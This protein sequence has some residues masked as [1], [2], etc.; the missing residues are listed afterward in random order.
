M[1]QTTR[2]RIR[3]HI[4]NVMNRT[5]HKL[6][7]ENPFNLDEV[8]EKN[9]F[10]CRLVP[11]EVWKGSKFE[12]SFVTTLGQGI[13]EQVAK[14]IAEGTG[15]YAENQHIKEVQVNTFQNETINNIIQDQRR[16]G[17]G[18]RIVSPNLHAELSH[19]SNLN[20]NSFITVSI[21]S[22]LYIR[23]ASG[24]EEYYSLKT[25]KPNL[26]QTAEAK[27][28]L[29]LLKT[30]NPNCEVFFALPYNPAGESNSYNDSGHSIPKKLFD[31]DDTN[32]VLIGSSMW[33]K[34][35]DDSNTYEELL[36]IFE[37]VG[38]YTT[39][40]IREEYFGYI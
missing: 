28:N 22:D 24:H 16:A 36:N 2:T 9:P 26:D 19:L 13:F 4:L 5:I 38:R 15:A 29:L 39:Q 27:R 37:E 25:V 30:E 6:T 3:T 35:G 10:G 8:R 20:T 7:I 11:S 14:I 1:D 17:R 12:R 34:I 31:M 23:R 21:I 18:R 33:N 40:R 32:F